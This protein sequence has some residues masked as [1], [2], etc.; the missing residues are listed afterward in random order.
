MS[1]LTDLFKSKIENN[2]NIRPFNSNK[3]VLS[4]SNQNLAQNING[5]S[6]VGQYS[7][8]CHI[9]E[10]KVYI[11]ERLNIMGLFIHSYCFRCDYCSHALQQNI[12]YS[13]LKDPI[14]KKCK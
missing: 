4:T 2:S 11:M 6:I 8:F 13:Y 1:S 12:P 5:N 7:T 9:C 10:V 14:T 3:K